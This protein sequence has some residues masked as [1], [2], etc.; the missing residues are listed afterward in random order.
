MSGSISGRPL[1]DTLM[2]IR[3]KRLGVLESQY[4]CFASERPSNLPR[5]KGGARAFTFTCREKK[6]KG[7]RGWAKNLADTADIAD[8]DMADKGRAQIR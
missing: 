7:R 3:L 5:A 2:R 4:R 8:T 1:M 6:E